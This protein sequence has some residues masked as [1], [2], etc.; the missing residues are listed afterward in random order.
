MGRETWLG[1]VSRS[2]GVSLADEIY[3]AAARF[4]AH[5]FFSAATIAFL[6]AVLS[7][8]LVECAFA[9]EGLVWFHCTR[10]FRRETIPGS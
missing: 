2:L 5:R 8:N 10:R 9:A 3:A 6:P 1:A 4:A 7:W